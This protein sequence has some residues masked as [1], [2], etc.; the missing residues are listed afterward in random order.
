VIFQSKAAQTPGFH[1]DWP[2]PYFSD[3]NNLEDIF[4]RD[5]N[6][7]NLFLLSVNDNSASG[8]GAS[9]KPVVSPDDR[10]V[11]YQSQATDIAPNIPAGAGFQIVAMDFARFFAQYQAHTT[12][13]PTLTG[14]TRLISYDS[15][16]M[17]MR[18]TMGNMGTMGTMGTSDTSGTQDTSDAT[19]NQSNPGLSNYNRMNNAGTGVGAVTPVP[20]TTPGEPGTGDTDN[21]TPSDNTS[22]GQ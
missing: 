15:S 7:G 9:L 19:K 17:G 3:A 8:N 18:G 22:P 11:V 4:A 14:F 21:T 6:A 16:G 2:D 12:T 20:N 13:T 1:Y 5:M 10:W